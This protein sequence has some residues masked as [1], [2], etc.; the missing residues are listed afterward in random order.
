MRKWDI[1]LANVK[2]EEESV[3]K[4]R[5]VIVFGENEYYVMS[6][7]STSQKKGFEDEYEIIEWEA[8][9]LDR[10]T[11][12]RINKMLEIHKTNLLHRIG[13]L[14]PIDILGIQEKRK[15]LK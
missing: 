14:H 5:P 6:F 12:A 4:V 13:R 1:F 2:Y 7:Y 9:Q 15:E 3:W 10:K 8:A 11:Y